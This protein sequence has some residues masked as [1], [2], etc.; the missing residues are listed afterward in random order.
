M[1]ST[2]SPSLSSFDLLTVDEFAERLKV[3]RTTVFGWL[4]S[5][6]LA[7]GVHYL[8]LGRILRFRSDTLFNNRPEPVE[9]E[10]GASSPVQLASR[11]ADFQPGEARVNNPPLPFKGGNAPVRRRPKAM[12]RGDTPVINL[13]Y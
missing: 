11:S 4:K 5:G 12:K 7:E 6:I 3:S 9:A 13:D 2:S 1:K 10:D 8:R